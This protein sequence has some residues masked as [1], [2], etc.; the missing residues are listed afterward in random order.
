MNKAITDGLV[1]MPTEFAAGLNVW[2][3][4][5]GTAGSDT[6]AGAANAALVTADQD[7]G[8]CLE[9]IKTQSTQKLRYMGQ[10]TI[11]P[12][13]YLQITARVKAISG[14]LPSVNI[15]GYAAKANGSNVSG[16]VQVGPSVALTAYGKVET[17]TAIVGT[18]SRGGVDMAWGTQAVYGHFGL[19]LTGSNGGTVRIDDIEITDITSAFLRD[20]MDWVDVRDYGAVGDGVTDDAAAFNAAD[21]AAAG[22]QILVSEGVYYL[23]S[24][25][26]IAA[27]IRFEGTLVMPVT[28][29]LSL[30]SSY[31]FPTY[32]DAFG[33]ELLGFKK[34]LQA[35]FSY[36]DHNAL[37]LCGRRV[38]VTEPID[39]RALAPDVATFSNRRVL[40]NGQ[41]NV[42]AG[43]AWNTTTVTSS[44]SYN[45]NQPTTLTSVTNI[46]N[47]PVG[48]RVTGTGVG[49]EVYV[50]AVNVGAS[51]LTLSQPFYGGSGT[52]TLTFTRDK[53]V[54]DFSG[55]AQLDRFNI[56]DVEFLCNGVAS[57]IMLAP[58]GQMFHLRDSYVVK[59]KARCIT[60]IGRGC[61]DMLVDRCQFLSD[62]QLVPAQSRTSLAININANDAKIRDSRFVRFGHTIIAD[63]SGHLFVGNHWF[64]GDEETNGV[65]VAGLILTQTNVQTAITGNY[66]DNSTIEWT[67]EYAPSPNFTGTEYSFGGLTVT[68][69]TFVCINVAPWFRW[70][71][72]KPYG[73]GH[74]IQGLNISCNVFKS[75]NGSID[76]IEKVD[77]TFA[78]LDRSRMRNILME[79]N[80]Y[81]AVTQFVSNP[82][83][84]EH[85][86]ATA[87]T[88][89]T[90][91]PGAYLPF[92][93]WARNVESLVAE[94][95]ITT[96]SGAR[97]SDMPY[98][99]VEQGVNNNQVTVNWP[100]AAKG[101]I[102]IRVRMDNPN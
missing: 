68:G 102:Q 60:S 6:Y 5:N 85:N 65:R 78:D 2:S 64:Q 22:R 44:A 63:G 57:C 20:M 93:G 88:V 47:I 7:F 30:L 90:V 19:D 70:F 72:M 48:A 52:R 76:R 21:A 41:F 75:L 59:P 35:L 99:G 13:C 94:G 39:V 15:A 18:G 29:R 86:Q 8:G 50:K 36:T 23:G 69:N 71:S 3:S 37:D 31:D 17:I 27:P 61:Q 32:A 73:S 77:T 74:Y 40:R 101:R 97:I 12:G 58:D 42:V 49:R 91:D 54:L 16:V 100:Q 56:D 62:E 25:V 67:N 55:M 66:I 80:I 95:M 84:L 46:A 81:N 14:N 79:G 34:A 1:F 43:A 33:D 98:V 38:E 9:M 96:G 83:F 11:L 4:E 24:S 87:Q 26:S 45:I 10:T 51:S 82:V 53:Y 28:A 89:W 92:D